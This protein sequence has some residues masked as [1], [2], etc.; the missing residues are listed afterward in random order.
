MK[1]RDDVGRLPNRLVELAVDD[2][3]RRGSHH[4]D[5]FARVGGR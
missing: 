3:R 2:G 4:P 5:G 1:V